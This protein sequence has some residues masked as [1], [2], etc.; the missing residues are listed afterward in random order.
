MVLGIDLGEKL[1]G[2]SN[3]LKLKGEEEGVIKDDYWCF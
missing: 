1:I 3:G 2:F